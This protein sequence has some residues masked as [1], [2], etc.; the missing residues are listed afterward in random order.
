M[1]LM[2]PETKGYTLEEM[3]EVFDSGRPAWK[4]HKRTSR[5]DQLARDIELGN[6]KI[7]AP[8]REGGT[9]AVPAAAGR[10]IAP[11]NNAENAEGATS[12]PLGAADEKK[13][14]T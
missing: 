11:E 1:T 2:A 13:A 8:G 12:R 9:G 3:D 7:T 14:E 10:G 4:T 5:L 6:V